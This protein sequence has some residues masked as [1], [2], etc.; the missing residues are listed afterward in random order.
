MKLFCEPGSQPWLEDLPQ[1]RRRAW[2]SS[3]LALAMVAAALAQLRPVWS[4]REV[5]VQGQGR[6]LIFMVDVSRSMLASDAH[7]NRLAMAIEVVKSALNVD[8][9][10]R[11]GLVYFAGSS[12]IKSP[13]TQDKEFI[14]EQLELASQSLFIKEET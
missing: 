8:P 12:S 9:G 13:L 1:A 3:L 6:D 10:D 11:Y 4:P 7:P 14:L 5:A 2:R